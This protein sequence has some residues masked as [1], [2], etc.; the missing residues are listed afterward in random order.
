MMRHS[1][2]NL[3]LRLKGDTQLLFGTKSRSSGNKLSDNIIYQSVGARVEC[4]YFCSPGSGSL[5]HPENALSIER[6]MIVVPDYMS[7]GQIVG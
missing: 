2:I 5:I 1:N 6:F 7:G 4:E 3:H